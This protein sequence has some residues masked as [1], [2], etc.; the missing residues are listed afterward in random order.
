VQAVVK[1]YKGFGR[2]DLR[3]K[4][5]AGH[6]LARA[7]QQ[8]R[9]YLNRLALQAQFNASFSQFGGPNIELKTVKPQNARNWSRCQHTNSP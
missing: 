4:L 7:I 2:P 1:I 3:P 6:E 5:F 8:G 9:Q